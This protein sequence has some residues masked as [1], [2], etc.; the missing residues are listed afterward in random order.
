MKRIQYH[1]ENITIHPESLDSSVAVKVLS[2]FPEAPILTSESP[3][4][5]TLTERPGRCLFLSPF[6]GEFLKPCP[7]TP[8]YIGCDYYVM[9]LVTNCI[10]ECTY[11]IL[12]AYLDSPVIHLFTNIEKVFP[13]LD[14]FLGENPGEFYRIGSGELSDSLIFDEI[15]GTASQLIAYFR[16]TSNAVLEL[17]TKTVNINHLLHLPHEGRTV[18][19]WSLNPS[20]AASREEIHSSPPPDRIRAAAQC[21]HEEFPVAFHF[22]PIIHY[23]GWEEGYT[24]IITDMLDSVPHQNIVWI[25][26]GT[27]RFMPELKT[28]SE[29]RYPGSSIFYNEFIRGMDGKCRYFIDLRLKLYRKIVNE[30]RRRAP[31]IPLYFCMESRDVWNDVLGWAPRDEFELR[32]YLSQRIQE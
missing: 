6:K 4:E 27:L 13:Q 18:L 12:Q 5:I 15:T 32:R 14:T 1:I 3:P 9:N 31:D 30:I 10:L 26:L 29:I 7:C 11:C 16:N 28:I 25:S 17:K 23:Q 19:A 21:A 8:E 2:A 20:D 24:Q 22:D